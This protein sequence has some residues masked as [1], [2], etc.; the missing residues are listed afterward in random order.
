MTVEKNTPQFKDCGIRPDLLA[1]LEQMFTQPTPIQHRVIP[2]AVTGKDVV[3]IAQTGTGKTLAF[4]VPLL[5]RLASTGAQG[6]VLVPTRELAM[7]VEEMLMKIGR[8]FH[9]RLALVIGGVPAGP[10]IRA[11]NNRP[12]IV[13]ATP[14]R[15]ADLLKQRQYSLRAVNIVVL[16][17]ADRMLDIGF[18]PQ[19]KEILSQAPKPR[20]TMLFSATMPPAIAE[21]A[22]QFMTQPLRIEVAPAGTTAA[23]VEQTVYFVG[24]NEKNQLIEKLL[25]DHSGLVLIFTRTKF[26]AKKLSRAIYQMGHASVEIHSNRTLAQRK[27]ALAGFKSGQYRV[28]VATDIAARGIDVKNIALVINY[29]VPDNIDDYVHRIG[30]TGRAGG[31]GQAITLATPDQK[32]DIRDIE[33]LVRKQIPVKAIP[34]LPPRR[35]I[36]VPK[37]EATSQHRYAAKRSVDFPQRSQSRHKSSYSQTSFSRRPNS[38][39]PRRASQRGTQF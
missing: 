33:R 39:R 2:I 11:L 15:L 30:R 23:N 27:A 37:F 22:R 35:Q 24:K 26:G 20:Q 12:Q 34:V 13:V 28:L 8:Q 5:Q 10:Q 31:A 17:E 38:R 7:Q 29:D 1:A 25:S 19:I 21:I 6:L 3:G 14:G 9:L 32:S 4:G 16:D 18:M 36:M